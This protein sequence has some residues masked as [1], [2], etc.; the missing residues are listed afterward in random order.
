M[1]LAP[2]LVPRALCAHAGSTSWYM[3]ITYFI[4]SSLPHCTGVFQNTYLTLVGLK[5]NPEH[6]S[7]LFKKQNKLCAREGRGWERRKEKVSSVSLEN[8]NTGMCV[9]SMH[10]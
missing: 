9:A 6:H 8:S 4:G 7:Q 3:G 10:F 2:A 1:A 5:M